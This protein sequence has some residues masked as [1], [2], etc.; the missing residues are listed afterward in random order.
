MST[1]A[2]FNN[3]PGNLKPQGFTYKGQIGLD[4]RGFAIFA[5]K[6]DGRNAL[7]HDIQVKQKNGINTPQSFIDKY[8]PAG[9][10][11][12][13]EG[14][15]NYKVGMAGHLG[16][17]STNDPFPENSVEKIAD[18][19]ERF[20]S[21]KAPDQTQEAPKANPNNPFAAGVPLA[22]KAREASNTEGSTD[23]TPPPEE[24]VSP[25]TAAGAGA[26]ISGV[27]Q[28]GS[29]PE[30]F[31]PA[32][33]INEI[34]E[35][36]RSKITALEESG[37][38]TI[39]AL[40][41]AEDKAQR[42][43]DIA[44]DRLQKRMSNPAPIA[45]GQT[46]ADLE[47]DFKISQYDLQ[48]ADRELK[49]RLNEQKAKVS[50]TPAAT[51]QNAP[52]TVSAA[53]ETPSIITDPNAPIQTAQERVLQG[54]IDPETGTT[55]RQRQGYNEVTSYQALLREQQQKALAE[56]QKLGLV[57]D[58]GES[59]RIAFGAPSSTPSGLLVQPDVAAPLN[60][61]AE[62]E[63]RMVDDK[64]AQERLAQ[65]NEMDRLKEERA[66]AAQRSSQAQ[67]ALTKAQSARTA[68]VTRAQTAAETAEDRALAARQDLESG[69]KTAQEILNENAAKV[70]A[71]AKA[72]VKAA[73]AAPSGAGRYLANTGVAAGK[74]G[75][76]NPVG[77]TT[78]GA[79]GGLQA[80]RGINELANM[81]IEELIKRYQAGERSP[82]L[83]AAIQQAAGA[84]A[85]TGFGAA[86]T[87][88]VVGPRTAKIK[89]AGALGTLGMGIY[90][91]YKALT[92]KEPQ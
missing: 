30:Y 62:L 7:I 61:Q 26:L 85:Q 60:A 55:G 90:E 25:V 57:K 44:A 63:Q 74:T 59:A 35:S 34:K 9:A 84:T 36:A 70:S 38:K 13:E 14:R 47:L 19:I 22:D 71:Q 17:K 12:L 5:T 58:V 83:L 56:A 21:G 81:P 3:N 1:V 73:K 88:P 51:T 72:D 10:E 82:E 69:R 54:T 43:H 24:V 29:Q 2:E 8:A 48:K 18:F 79:I 39:A 49:A 27:G 87:V 92:E 68:G 6:Q 80:A 64:A 86:A 15:D 4:D 78:I 31:G 91:G 33:D 41:E 37:N 67:S 75:L 42:R 45:G 77:R 16:L 76:L 11:N 52:Q 66:L 89:G 53:P 65:Q 46:L 28:L 40:Q 23:T 20:E 50:P 32:P